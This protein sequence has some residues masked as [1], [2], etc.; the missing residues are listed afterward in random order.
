MDIL[1]RGPSMSRGRVVECW[2]KSVIPARLR[3]G[4]HAGEQDATCGFGCQEKLPI[5]V[6][7]P[8]QIPWAVKSS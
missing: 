2:G 4:V 8:S 5:T 7:S 6:P 3:R 1:S